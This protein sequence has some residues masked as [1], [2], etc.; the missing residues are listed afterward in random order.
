MAKV[1]FQMFIDESQKSAL[2]RLQHDSGTSVA[3]LV[4]KAI[5]NFLSEYRRKKEVPIEDETIKKLLSV[6]GICKGGPKDLADN[7]DHY[8]Y[9]MPKKK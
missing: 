5:D 6:A 3:E 7:H 8:L 9:G 1:R 4:R 2:E